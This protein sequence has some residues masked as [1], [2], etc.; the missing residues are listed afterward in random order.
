MSGTASRVLLVSSFV[1][2]SVSLFRTGSQFENKRGR[3]Q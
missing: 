3:V 2:L 1:R